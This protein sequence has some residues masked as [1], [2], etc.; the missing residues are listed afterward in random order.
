MKSGQRSMETSTRTYRLPVSL[1]NGINRRAKKERVSPADIVRRA[2]VEYI[3]KDDDVLPQK[4]KGKKDRAIRYERTS[5]DRYVGYMPKSKSA[6]FD[7]RSRVEHVG[8]IEK[9]A[10]KWFWFLTDDTSAGFAETIAQAMND[11]EAHVYGD[12][13]G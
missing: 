11:M 1:I 6:G 10:G 12:A 13:N 4:R 3:N 8:T 5:K 7:Y 9:R 2:L